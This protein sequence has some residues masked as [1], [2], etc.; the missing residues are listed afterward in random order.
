LGGSF[1]TVTAIYPTGDSAAGD[2]DGAGNQPGAT[3]S[4]V[5]VAAGNTVV[6]YRDIN[7][8]GGSLT[9]T[10]DAPNLV[11]LGFNDAACFKSA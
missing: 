9:L 6:L 11:S 5:K 4:S 3:I 1:F 10:A 7:Y 8:T 2:R